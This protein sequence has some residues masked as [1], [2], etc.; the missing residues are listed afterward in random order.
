VQESEKNATADLLGDEMI[1]AGTET[2]ALDVVKTTDSLDETV[3]CSM[4][5]KVAHVKAEMIEPAEKTAMSL[6]SRRK[7]AAGPGPPL[8]KSASL[9]L[10]LPIP[11]L[12]SRGEDA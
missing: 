9:L 4:I 11:S 1:E 3:I 12:Y 6:L 10:T 8:R 2:A 5:G 7:L